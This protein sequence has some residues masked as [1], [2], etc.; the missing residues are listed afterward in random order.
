MTAQ[1]LWSGEAPLVLASGSVIRRA[2]LESVEIPLQIAPADLDERSIEHGLRTRSAQDVAAQLSA[3]K[4]LSVSQSF[5]GQYVLGADQT[6]AVAASQLHKPRD[7]HEAA[8]HLERLSG[9]AH[10]LHS[11]LALAINGHVIWT[12]V[13]TATLHMRML[14]AAFIHDYLETAGD[15]VLSSVGAYQIEGLGMHLFDKIEGDHTTIMG[16][17]LLPLLRQFRN[18]GLVVE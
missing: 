17:P 12:H 9:R 18:M 8:R 14:S 2:L 16:M 7:R 3:A 1:I 13:E 6:L 5:A 15:T 10:Q 11:G 4:A